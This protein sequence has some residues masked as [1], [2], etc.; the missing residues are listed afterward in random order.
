[1]CFN[2]MS[3]KTKD[4]LVIE[5]IANALLN[6]SR[7]HSKRNPRYAKIF[8]YDAEWMKSNMGRMVEEKENGGY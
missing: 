1:M 4:E 2:T 8:Q 6:L 3:M 5:Y 7:L